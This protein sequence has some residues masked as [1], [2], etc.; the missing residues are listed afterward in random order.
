MSMIQH[1]LNTL[2]TKADGLTGQLSLLTYL[3]TD[4]AELRAEFEAIHDVS[5]QDGE[6]IPPENL[7]RFT[8]FWGIESNKQPRYLEGDIIVSQLPVR[9]RLIEV[10][11]LMT[12]VKSSSSFQLGFC[13]DSEELYLQI[14]TDQFEEELRYIKRVLDWEVSKEANDLVEEDLSLNGGQEKLTRQ[15]IMLKE[16]NDQD[17]KTTIHGIV[18][19][20]ILGMTTK[21]VGEILART[22]AERL[23]IVQTPRRLVDPLLGP[24]ITMRIQSPGGIIIDVHNPLK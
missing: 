12:E 21:D 18:G 24:A 14:R 11:E 3:T 15:K 10:S 4:L 16:P 1:R 7:E 23:R 13:P 22:H 9:I 20:P 17:E 2:S 19:G 5:F 8:A 6:A